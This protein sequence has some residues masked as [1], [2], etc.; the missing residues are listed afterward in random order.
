MGC[1]IILDILPNSK[2]KYRHEVRGGV[3]LAPEAEA[4]PGGPMWT[5][6]WEPVGSSRSNASVYGD[7]R[8]FAV[9]NAAVQ[10]TSSSSSSPYS[11]SHS[12]FSL[13]SP[14]CRCPLVL[15]LVLVLDRKHRAD[16]LHVASDLLCILVRR[17]ERHDGLRDPAE[18]EL[19]H[20]SSERGRFESGEHPR[21]L[22]EEQLTFR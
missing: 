12:S 18:S 2:H 5:A 14:R 19:E 22:L 9:S 8:A 10:N 13:R 16:A 17:L 3:K 11:S 7:H 4:R 1:T 6:A 15:V 20:D 21:G